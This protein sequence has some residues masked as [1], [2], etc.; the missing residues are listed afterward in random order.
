MSSAKLPL[1]IRIDPAIID[2]ARIKAEM[3]N[4]S[5]ANYVETLI[6]NDTKDD[7]VKERM[8]KRRVVVPRTAGVE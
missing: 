7:V 6:V 5:L 8:V 3:Q 2:K 1:S 4:R